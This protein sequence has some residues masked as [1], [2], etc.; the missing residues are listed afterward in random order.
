VDTRE[1]TVED[2]PA[3]V[4]LV[5]RCD[6]TYAE[7]AGDWTPPGKSDETERWEKLMARPDGWSWGTFDDATLVSVVGWRRALDESESEIP[8][9]AQVVSVF[10]DPDRWGQGL[11][12]HLLGLA[13]EEMRVQ[14]YRVARLW[15]PRDAPARDFYARQNWTLDGR[16]KFESKFG[17]HLVGYE[18]RLGR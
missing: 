8:G 5:A 3:A 11:A 1:L 15:T 6:V 14:G 4:D 17:L 12:A 10:T 9:V 18:K 7:W 2:V 16:A 13:E